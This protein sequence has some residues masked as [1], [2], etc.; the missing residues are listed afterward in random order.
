MKKLN[1]G[2]TLIEL[3]VVIAIIGILSATVLTSLNSARSRAKAASAQASL[4]GVVPAAITCLDDGFTLNT[5]DEAGTLVCTNAA[6]WPTLPDGWDYGA[7]SSTTG[8]P[9]TF[10]FAANNGTGSGTFTVT[11][12]QT[13]CQKTA[14]S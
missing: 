1:K 10:S 2:F 12:T 7:T 3:L 9:A 11:C 8:D 5:A 13:G 4:A 6:A 14:N